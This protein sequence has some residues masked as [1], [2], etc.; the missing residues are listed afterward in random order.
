MGSAPLA[1]AQDDDEDAE[2][3]PGLVATYTSA[4][5]T[6][7]VRL[8]PQVAFN[9]REQPP[10]E[11]IS[12]DRFQVHWQ[13]Q[14][15]LQ[16][17]GLFRFKAFATG[18]VEFKLAGKIVLSG[19]ADEPRWL[20][21]QPVELPFGFHPLEVS[22]QK[23]GKQA[24]IALFWSGPQFQLEPLPAR[25]LSHLAEHKVDTRFERGQ[26]LARALRCAACHQTSGDTLPLKAPALDQLSG[27]INRQWLVDW[28]VAAERE[29]ATDHAEAPQHE[30]V[31]RMPTLGLS[32]ADAEAIALYLTSF[33]PADLPALP[34]SQLPKATPKKDGKSKK[35]SEK[36]EPE[37]PLVLNDP[38]AGGTLL[39]SVGCLACHRVGELGTQDLFG[40]GDLTAIAAKR[41]A[42]FFANWLAHPE[43][44]NRD[45]RMPVFRLDP[46][47]I[48]HVAAHLK[49]LGPTPSAPEKKYE[50]AAAAQLKRGK[51]LV[52]EHRCGAC[53]RL[54]EP[55]D[56]AA[57]RH[58]LA[59]VS[60]QAAKQ[61]NCLGE[62]DVQARRPGYRLP[63][64]SRDALVAY[65]QPS[66]HLERLP[67]DV[68]GSQLLAERNCLACHSRETSPGLVARLGPV[69]EAD[70]ALRDFLPAMTPPSLLGIGDKLQDEH[71][72][73][74][75]TTSRPPR[76][77]WLR[78]RMPRFPLSAAEVDA[79]AQYLIDV[80][81]IPDLPH[82]ETLPLDPR[83]AQTAGSR[84][85]TADGFGC[86]SCHT[87]NEWQPQKVALNARGPDLAMMAERLR[88][89]WYDRWMRNPARIV[90]RMEMPAVQV[91]IRGVLGERLDQQLDSVWHALNMPGFNPPP[92]NAL[93]VVR[94]SN[95]PGA[96]ERA[97]VLTDLLEVGKQPFV[98]PLVIGLPNRHN[99]M[100]DFA[101]ASLSA[102][103]IGD[104]ARQRTRGKGWYWEAAGTQLLVGDADDEEEP[105]PGDL[106][107]VM[108]GQIHAPVLAGQFPTEL[109][110]YELVAGGVQI[111]HRLHYELD[112]Q[113]LSLPVT[114]TLVA[115]PPTPNAVS[116]FR[117][118]LTITGLP[119]SV[120]LQLRVL[121]PEV[122][123]ART[124]PRVL[125][126]TSPAATGRVVLLSP[127]AAEFESNSSSNLAIARGAVRGGSIS[128]ELAYQTDLPVDQ[129]VAAALP[130]RS[131]TKQVLDVVPGFEAIRLPLSDEV[132]PTGLAW[133]HRG[134]LV[135]CSLN[136]QVFF[137]DDTD[138]DGL[139]DKLAVF[140]D[141]LSAPYGVNTTGD[142]V[143]V[144]NKYALVRLEDTDADGSADRLTTLASGWGHTLDYHD[145]AVG[146]PRD[147][148]GNYYVALPCQ[149][150]ERGPAAVALRSAVIKLT[151][152]EPS[153]DNPQRFAIEQLAAGMR[154]P[155]GIA[156]NRSGDLF[157]SDNQGN[158]TPFNELNHVVAGRRYGFL[159]RWE[160]KA[161]LKPPSTS[162]AIEIP[163]PWTRSVNGLCFLE[164]PSDET[165]SQT[166][167][168]PFAGHLIG[169]EYDTS[170]L[171]RMSLELVDGE[172][173]GAV[174]PFSSPPE[175]N[176]AG[177]RSATFQGPL[178][179][180]VSP[181]GDVY[182]GN[183]R[184]SG[185]G[186]G[187]NIGSI[188]RL[189]RRGEVPAG[190]AE[191]RAA[192]RGFEIEFTQPVDA[193]LAGQSS[194]YSVSS[195]RRTPTSSYGGPDQDRR[196]E[197][198]KSV[199]LSGDRRIANLELGEFRTG[200][201]YEIRLQKLLPQ[202]QSF[203]PDE[204]HYTLRRVPK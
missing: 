150:D 172:Y 142:A 204:A 170:R 81:R 84:L 156:R 112:G 67:S 117:R 103:W 159:N 173:Q 87:I 9:W 181:R 163:H 88:R 126:F 28:L 70:V 46:I 26:I 1:L 191:V 31:R 121:P 86:T 61:A 162:A 35:S 166:L 49:T 80:D 155:M 19:E 128:I 165:S 52:A 96:N 68:T 54:P 110:S 119:K 109:D 185:W 129:F 27:Q 189:R 122:S 44:L 176:E 15:L 21:G 53:H 30:V 120:A 177:E 182:V 55:I 13:G 123:V 186:A 139:E 25:L 164:A 97:S 160:V 34:Q 82:G 106:G 16:S 39:R 175:L 203:F 132:M 107:L 158:Y 93:R 152:R 77:P 174:Y 64:K 135:I 124:D 23:Q 73:A 108:Q 115:E 51:T 40:G 65:L 201:V 199:S 168:G 178:V 85:V 7:H 202:G 94:A 167:F 8:D 101:S 197:K 6:R 38:V 137:A 91:P 194:N 151:P 154:F 47:E 4:A 62:S 41:P 133:N 33:K 66:Q 125:R 22:Y 75:I 50:T 90:P 76:R 184:D 105:I 11:P 71:L 32:P 116:G 99:L 140:A 130:D 114:Q 59:A 2:F 43:R 3:L 143:D 138:N 147:E 134:R 171:V 146:L 48:G 104:T 24:Q 145:W 169:C 17:Q 187:S 57:T 153:A 149:Q 37:T 148:Q 92:P 180:G 10:L 102:W 113:R 74:A 136:D 127:A 83:V 5:G 157:T 29:A 141:G 58:S 188:V 78:V 95:L 192:A 190:I 100:Y 195:Y 193:A 12:A 56:P 36:K 45:H 63:E 118:R 183:I 42:E 131:V 69:A 18:R 144:V 14:L 72:R 20:E 198:L 196:I 60:G 161:G 79:L 179:C 111:R 98:K 89:P 200:F